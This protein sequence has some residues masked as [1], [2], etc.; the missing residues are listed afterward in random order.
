[1]EKIKSPIDYFSEITDPLIDR[2]KK[3]LLSYTIFIMI[4][5]VI[6]GAQS[7]IDNE[8]I[9]DQKRNGCSCIQRLLMVFIRMVF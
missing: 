5:V 3:H 9:E 6:S 4:A 8:S 2:C 1:L 7:W